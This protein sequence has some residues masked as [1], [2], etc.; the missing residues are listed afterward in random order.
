[1]EK[2]DGS[3]QPCMDYKRSEQNQGEEQVTLPLIPKLFERICRAK[4]FTMLYM[5]GL[6]INS[7]LVGG[8]VENCF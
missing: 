4:I 3:L 6:Q 5:L 2:M 1:M 7:H 8:Q